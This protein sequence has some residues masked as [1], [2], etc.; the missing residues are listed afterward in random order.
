MRPVTLTLVDGGTRK[1]TVADTL[2]ELT[3]GFKDG[4]DVTIKQLK[5]ALISIEK[6]RSIEFTRAR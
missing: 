3:E 4:D 2:D 6:I 1:G 5:A